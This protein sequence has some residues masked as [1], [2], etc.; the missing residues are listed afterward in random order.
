MAIISTGAIAK[1][2]MPGVNQFFGNAYNEL[3]M[4]LPEIFPMYRSDKNFEEDVDMY[5]LGLATVKQE[6]GNIA[7]DT[8]GQAFVKRYVHVVYGLGF[9]L[10]REHVEDNQ[11][12]DLAAKRARMLAFAMRQ[13]KEN[14]A[15]NVLNRAFNSSYTGGDGLELCS[16]AH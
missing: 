3:P 8:F 13:T 15:A 10:T 4:E 11:Y 14:V 1:A 12:M 16:T 7:Y 2:L 6:A 5:G 9:I